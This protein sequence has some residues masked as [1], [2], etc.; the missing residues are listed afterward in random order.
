MFR[1]NNCLNTST[2]PRISFDKRGVCNACQWAEEKKNINWSKRQSLLKNFFKNNKKKNYDCI[3]PVSG[4]KDGSYVSYNVKKKFNVNTLCTVSYTH[5]T[6]PTI[7][8]V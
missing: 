2:R 7:L 3:I 6:L 4:G 1:C 8:L 5:L